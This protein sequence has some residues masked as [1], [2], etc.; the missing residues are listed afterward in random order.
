MPFLCFSFR[1][2]IKQI[3]DN[4][5]NLKLI[6]G[7]FSCE[8]ASE[9]LKNIFISKINFHQ[10]KNF[11]TQE[12]AGMEDTAATVRITALK[13]EMASLD[14][15]ISGARSQNKKLIIRSEIN[16]SLLND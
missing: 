14:E 8:E 12:Q 16:I 5:K 6:E 3:M 11:K 7:E 4:T 2:K 1:I 13:Q 9:I 15:I 10:L